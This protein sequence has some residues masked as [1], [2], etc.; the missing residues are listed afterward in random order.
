MENK[1]GNDESNLQH[2]EDNN[3]PN[4]SDSPI[5]LF[6]NIPKALPFEALRRREYCGT[7]I[8]TGN[9]K[10]INPFL[11]ATCAWYC[12]KLETSTGKIQGFRSQIGALQE[13]YKIKNLAGKIDWL[14][15]EKF[16]AI[17]K[18]SISLI[19][20]RAL[21]KWGIDPKE[22]LPAIKYDTSQNFNLV[23]IIS[24]IGIEQIM[25][26]SRQA[27]WRKLNSNPDAIKI[28]TAIFIQYGADRNLLK[29]DSEYFRKCHEVALLESF[30]TMSPGQSDYFILHE[31]LAD[32]NPDINLNQATY[33]KL[34]GYSVF[35]RV[36]DKT[37]KDESQ[38]I[39]FG[40]LKRRL[41]RK[42]LLSLQNISAESVRLIGTGYQAKLAR[43]DESIF[44]HRFKK[45]EKVRKTIWYKP[46]QIEINHSLIYDQKPV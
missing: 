31:E 10:T 26:K 29:E 22:K 7:H 41:A 9:G 15:R 20:E 39:G 43:K 40:H 1:F 3:L 25:D 8:S 21:Y 28:L 38:C 35:E 32:F 30:R 2:H 4:T 11:S 37:K 44:H 12:L 17:N 27:Y 34:I 19:G 24:T 18:D 16:L 33:G 42:R 13:K 45:G 46:T 5:H 36:N 23:D 14:H 6:H